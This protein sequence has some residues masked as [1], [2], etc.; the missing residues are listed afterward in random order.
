MNG[1]S[2]DVYGAIVVGTGFGGAV[3]GSPRRVSTWP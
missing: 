3:A 1:L 2:K